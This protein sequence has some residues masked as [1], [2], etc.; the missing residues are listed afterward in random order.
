MVTNA[1]WYVR[2][3]TI[4]TDMDIPTVADILQKTYTAHHRSMLVHFNPLIEDIAP[5][6]PPAR[7][8]R[9]LKR[10]RHTDLTPD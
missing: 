3:T 6:P 2:N 10:K 5:N 4:H 7:Q 9:H 8:Q 1:P